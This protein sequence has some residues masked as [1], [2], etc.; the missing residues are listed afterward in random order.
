MIVI[1]D[2]GVLPVP[3]KY[4][5]ITIALDVHF[6]I[7]S[8]IILPLMP[9]PKKGVPEIPKESSSYILK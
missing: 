7:K 4:Q 8:N 5:N 6:V 1:V 3:R 9:S 2:N